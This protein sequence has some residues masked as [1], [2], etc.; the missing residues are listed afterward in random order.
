MRRGHEVAVVDRGKVGGGMTARTSAHLS[1]EI[2]DSYAELI[3][4]HDEDRAR[5]YYESQK[6][7]IDRIEHICNEE[8]IECDFK[9]VDLYLFAPDHS[10]RRG[11]EH[12]IK[13]ATQIGFG[14]VGWSDAPVAGKSTGCL[15][16]PDQ[17]RFHPLSYLAGLCEA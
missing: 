16:F 17:A 6:A 13:A 12:E 7:A 2:D 15:R 10:G 1:S 3:N 4:A 9:R 14:G 5:Q 8:R 11:L